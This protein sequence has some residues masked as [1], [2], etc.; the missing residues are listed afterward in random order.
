VVNRPVS[1]DLYRRENP[2]R[3]L[4]KTTESFDSGMTNSTTNGKQ[5]TQISREVNQLANQT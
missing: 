5:A 1:L 2:V 3:G 4:N